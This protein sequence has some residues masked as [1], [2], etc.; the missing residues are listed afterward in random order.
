MQTSPFMCLNGEIVPYED[1]KIHA[2]AGVVKYG[3]AV[4][5][6][7]RGYWNPDHEEMYVF[8]MREHM[9]RLR[10]GMRVMRFDTVYEPE[11]TEDCLMRMIR[12]NELKEAVHLRMIAFLEGDDELAMAGPIGLVC[13]A[14]PRPTAQRVWDGI[15]VMV[16]SYTR[17]AD[18]AIPPRVK[19]SSNYAN[20]RFAELESRRHGYDGVLMLTAR[21]T[22]S[23]GSGACLFIVR[24]GTLITPDVTSGILESVTRD[25][26]I[27]LAREKLDLLVVER[28]IDRHELYAA[29][30]AFW[31]GT[32]HE[33]TPIVSV[34][35]MD[36]GDGDVGPLT[37]SIRDLYFQVVKGEISD[38]P[39]WRSPVYGD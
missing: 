6:G 30:E 27:R 18:N 15:H 22:V 29:Q 26:V 9:E 13:G 17:I 11:H 21:G 20:N 34:D 25:S 23:E 14:V 12:A 4:F 39:E 37:K 10:F 38:Y 28:E 1:A 35:R 7:L 2:F 3:C 36:V 8:R 32:A 16:S 5:E 33:V 24:D 31:C 19:S